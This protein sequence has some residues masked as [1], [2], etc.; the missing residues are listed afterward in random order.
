MAPP[1]ARVSA[2]AQRPR[3]G[4]RAATIT[5]HPLW[6]AFRKVRARRRSLCGRFFSCPHQL[7]RSAGAPVTR[8]RAFPGTKERGRKGSGARPEV[9][10]KTS[11]V[12]DEVEGGWHG[13]EEGLEARNQAGQNRTVGAAALGTPGRLLAPPSG[14]RGAGSRNNASSGASPRG[15]WSR[16]SARVCGGT[17][18]QTSQTCSG[19]LE[20]R[21]RGC[22]G[23]R[24]PQGR[25]LE[26]GRWKREGPHPIP[27]PRSLPAQ[28]LISWLIRNASFGVYF[29]NNLCWGTELFG[30]LSL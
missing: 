25:A 15:P 17:P 9:G 3:L 22:D 26:L 21:A 5:K 20:P 8:T 27:G 11:P 29:Q 28:A 23:P 24:Q 2:V 10:K 14:Q 18:P 16:C 12:P 6:C 4:R 1:R 30:L 13:C 19:L 7:A